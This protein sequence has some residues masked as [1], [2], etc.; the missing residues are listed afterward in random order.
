MT[1]LL[2]VGWDGASHNYLEEIQL[3]Y[4][5]SLQNQGKL[6][7]ED[8]YK[9]IP[10][11]SGT[12]WTTI[13]TGT[14]VN[15]HGF[16]SINNVVKSKSFLNFTKS[17]AKL[18]P[19]RKL[20][21]Y[22]FYG[23]NKL[24]NLKDRTPRSQDV[25][26]KRLW[27]YID[28]S[29]TVSVPLTYP[30]WKHNGVMFSGIPA[31]KDGALPTSYPQSYEDYRKRIN[32]YNYLGGK[33]TPLEESSKPNLQEYKD[34]IYELN[35][36]AFQVVEE[37]DEERDFQLIFGVFPIID[38]LLHALDPED[39]RDEIEAAYEWI[40]NRTQELVEKVNPD[41]VL[42]LSDHGMMPAEE[43]LNPNQYPGLEMDHDPMNGIWA[44]NTDLELEEQ[45]D[46]TPKIL[47]LFGKEFKK[48]KFEMEVEPDTEEFEDIKV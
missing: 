24:F 33:K 6:L 35:E 28:D 14:G 17:I 41:N 20:R 48:E 43:S 46:V 45:K 22:A 7:P 25:Q 18:I 8:V 12:A 27:D 1:K 13:T 9:G 16:L 29:L 34:R 11:D 36:E 23:P 5:G 4:Y 19:N 31:P 10:I 39:N 15:E 40:D 44:S 32:A 2:V 37:L 3:D 26:Y 42:I 21:T 30:A 38:D 47:E